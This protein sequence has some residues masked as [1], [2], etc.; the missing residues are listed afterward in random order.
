MILWSIR[1]VIV[2]AGAIAPDAWRRHL[3]LLLAA[4]RPGGPRL[5]QPPLT[6]DQVRRIVSGG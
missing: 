6:R 2:T 3:S 1:G 4:V 5:A